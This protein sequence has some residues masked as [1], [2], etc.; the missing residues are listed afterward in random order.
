MQQCRQGKPREKR[1]AV[2]K[3]CQS[4]LD[5]CQRRMHATESSRSSLSHECWLVRAVL[6]SSIEIEKKSKCCPDMVFLKKQAQ[7]VEQQ[8]GSSSR[9]CLWRIQVVPSSHCSSSQSFQHGRT[10]E[11]CETLS[12]SSFLSFL[13]P[14]R[15][16]SGRQRACSCHAM[17]FC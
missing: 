6:P 5:S 9:R 2:A 8:R 16:Y 11:R 15:G 7:A 17:L 10:G 4:L 1:P 12:V 3:S 14:S 13:F